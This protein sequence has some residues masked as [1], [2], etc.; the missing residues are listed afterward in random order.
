MGKILI[1]RWNSNSEL[2][3]MDCIQK[4]GFQVIAFEQKM[5]DYHADAQFAQEFL[6][7]VHREEPD[8][9][10][11]Y[12]YFPLVAS[13]CNMNHIPY[14][15]WIYDWPLYTLYSPTIRYHT[16]HI[17]CFDA[18]GVEDLLKRGASNVYHL[19]LGVNVE[20]KTQ[21]IQKTSEKRKDDF[22]S[23]VSFVGSLYN[24][25]KNRFRRMELTDYTRGYAEGII[26]AQLQVYGYHFVP[27][28]LPEEIVREIQLAGKLRLGGYYECNDKQLVADCISME[29]TAREREMLIADIA[30]QYE[31]CVY[32]A[33]PIPDNFHRKSRLYLKGPVNNQTELPLIYAASK[34]NLNI[35]SRTITSGIPLRVLEVLACGGFLI[36]NYQPEIAEAFEDGRELVM[37]T[38]RR[39]CMDKVQYYLTHDEERRRIAA[40]GRRA[41]RERFELMDMIKRMLE[42]L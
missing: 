36:T 39:D 13:L 14:L 6:K 20:R 21:L 9:V 11:S 15:A 38:D 3:F 40:N 19:P 34:I 18:S 5:T 17:F 32:T 4:L 1:Y 2:E 42:M 30:D 41:V 23:D 8:L 7:I 16:N 27:Q 12:D 26:R 35:S 31:T 24:E 29:I 28:I 25:E 33:S 10:F 37:Y 22:R